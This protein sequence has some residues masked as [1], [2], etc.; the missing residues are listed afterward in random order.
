MTHLLHFE[1][2]E[3]FLVYSGKMVQRNQIS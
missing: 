2:L 3:V 1:V